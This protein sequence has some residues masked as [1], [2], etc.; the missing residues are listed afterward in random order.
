LGNGGL[1]SINYENLINKK[2][3]YYNCVFKGDWGNYQASIFNDE[4]FAFGY[5]VIY[6]IKKVYNFSLD[7]SY[8][9]IIDDTFS[10]YS[11]FSLSNKLFAA[12]AAGIYQIVNKD[13]LDKWKNNKKY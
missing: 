8:S 6:Y 3:N 10:Y 13:V 7:S 5:R 9:M 11:R 12:G 4:I 2:E 1:F